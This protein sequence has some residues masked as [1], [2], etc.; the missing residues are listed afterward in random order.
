MHKLYARAK[1]R[2]TYEKTERISRGVYGI[3]SNLPVHMH[4]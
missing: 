4:A 2:I 3:N 1:F